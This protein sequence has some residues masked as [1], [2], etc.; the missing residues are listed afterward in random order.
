MSPERKKVPERTNNTDHRELFD[1]WSRTS[2]DEKGELIARLLDNTSWWHEWAIS[3]SLAFNW[4][5][6]R[7]EKAGLPWTPSVTA[8]TAKHQKPSG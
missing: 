4:I 8:K 3:D 7:F 6:T 5:K 2:E 1:I